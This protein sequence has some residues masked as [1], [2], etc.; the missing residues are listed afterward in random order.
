L[1]PFSSLGLR[2]QLLALLLPAML[3]IT[4]AELWLTRDDAVQA[5]NAA[6]DRSL[7]GAIKALDLNVS[8]ASGGLAV[9]LPYRL[10]EFFQLTATGSVY[11]RVATTDGLVEIGSPD[12]PQPPQP[13][14]VGVPQFYDA[15][16][17]G[18]AVRL[19]AYMRALDRPLGPGGAQQIVIQ[20]AESIESRRHF[21]SGFVRRTAVRDLLMLALMSIALAAL[22]ALA[23][24]PL[25]RLAA[26][27]RARA[28][29][30]LRPLEAGRLPADVEP[31]V[32]AVNQQ[33]GRTQALVEQRRSFID[34][35]SHQLRTPLATLRTQLDYALREPDAAARQATLEAL[36]AQLD[37]VTRSTNQLLALARSDAAPLQWQRFD[38]GA[39]VREL[40]VQFLPPARDKGLDFGI[41]VPADPCLVEG[42][43]GLLREALANL[44]HN[45]VAHARAGGE[46]TLQA[47]ADELGCSLVVQDGGPGLP[48]ELLGRLG[49]RFAKGR[50][51][52][53]SGLGL[54]I[55]QS[56][57]ERHGG[58]LRLEPR[59]AGGLRAA[60][61][62][63]R[64]GRPA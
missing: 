27:V 36:S 29:N 31:L 10:F 19:G 58:R 62:W 54:A 25:V 17:F 21:T 5:A 37:H 2:A 50:G 64:Q 48:P 63:P 55:A 52:S 30:D 45:A 33:L 9:E 32:D 26:Q 60:L 22:L 15:L 47:A 11:F 34:D 7:L 51:S 24:R 61:W 39:L 42:D 56:V 8:T 6:Y 49:E 14:A 12:L 3:A 46:V 16:Y 1:K 28:A 4:A 41:E 23:L 20:V 57:I 40:A 44:V 53:G 13:L 59:E 18:E 43:P 35:A 38:A